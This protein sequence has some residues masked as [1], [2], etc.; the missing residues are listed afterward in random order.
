PEEFSKAAVVLDRSRELGL[1]AGAFVGDDRIDLPGYDALD[2]LA[3]EGDFL[4][5]KVAVDSDEVPEELLRRADLIVDGPQE[6]VDLLR[7]LIP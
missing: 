2:L 5:L 1:N 6:T 7:R 3:S 4:A